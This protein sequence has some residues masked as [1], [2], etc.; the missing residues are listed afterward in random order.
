MIYYPP[1]ILFLLRARQ[2]RS[3]SSIFFPF[4]A[5]RATPPPSSPRLPLV[6]SSLPSLALFVPRH[7]SKWLTASFIIRLSAFLHFYPKLS[8]CLLFP[9]RIRTITIRSWRTSACGSLSRCRRF[10]SHLTVYRDLEWS[11]LNAPNHPEMDRANNEIHICSQVAVDIL[12]IFE[13][14]RVAL[15]LAGT[16]RMNNIFHVSPRVMYFLQNDTE[17]H[18]CHGT[19]ALSWRFI[20]GRISRDPESHSNINSRVVQGSSL[21]Y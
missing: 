18:F 4:T 21:M 1:Q 11:R 5:H 19:W 2:L 7:L 10:C 12:N 17:N 14:D 20:N 16:E 9:Q 8:R 6:G 15:W 13:G 3:R